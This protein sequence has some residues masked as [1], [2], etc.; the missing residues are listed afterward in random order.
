MNTYNESNHPI[1]LT[2]HFI[3]EGGVLFESFKQENILFIK[4]GERIIRVD[5]TERQFRLANPN[6]K[7]NLREQEEKFRLQKMFQ[8]PDPKIKTLFHYANN[9][10]Q[11]EKDSE[12]LKKRMREQLRYKHFVEREWL[13]TELKHNKTM[14][15]HFS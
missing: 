10:I 5:E 4:K 15:R 3:D 13:H 7:Q 8:K 9:V 6:E 1:E 14:W 2:H 11:I 12:E